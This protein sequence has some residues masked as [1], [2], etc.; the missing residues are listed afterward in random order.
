MK[1]KEVIKEYV[2][3]NGKTLTLCSATQPSEVIENANTEKPKVI[4]GTLLTVGWAVKDPS[5]ITSPP[6][7]GQLIAKG[8]TRKSPVVELFIRNNRL[9][10]NLLTTITDAVAK[11]MDERFYSFIPL[12]SNGKKKK[13]GG[14]TVN[15]EVIHTEETTVKT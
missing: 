3:K 7:L 2:L 1:N 9:S 6:E 8:R 15:K 13:E 11:E 10:D 14:G 5:D 4:S 12:G